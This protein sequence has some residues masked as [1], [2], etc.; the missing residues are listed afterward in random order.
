LHAVLLRHAEDVGRQLRRQQLKARTI[1]LKIKHADFQQVT[2][3]KTNKGAIQSAESIFKEAQ[4]LLD[5]YSLNRK[6][7]L[8]GVGASNFISA[9]APV[10]I[11]LFGDS[12]KGSKN[13]EKVDHTVDAINE[14][15]GRGFISK[16][17][18]VTADRKTKPDSGE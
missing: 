10:Q 2:R 13:W 5:Q 8:I 12:A 11:D 14:K 9:G 15:F 16:A 4:A 3:S 6:V 1:T 7:R 17:T 18:L